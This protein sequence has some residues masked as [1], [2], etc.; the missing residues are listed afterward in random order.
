M[1]ILFYI[2]TDNLISEKKYKILFK[3][4]TNKYLLLQEINIS[5][6]KGKLTFHTKL[7]I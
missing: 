2:K 4:S 5:I 3:N 7:K 1:N 6:L